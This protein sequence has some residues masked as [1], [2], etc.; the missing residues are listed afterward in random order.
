M[1]N[2][3][4]CGGG[5]LATVCGGFLSA[6]EGVKVS[7]LT[8][9]PEAWSLTPIV[10]APNGQQ[11]QGR[12]ELVT[13][14]PQE[15]VPQA[16]IVLL[17][18]PAFAIED[19]LQ[20]IKPWL[21]PTTVVGSIVANTGFFFAAHDLLPATQPLFGFQRVPFIARTK[22]YGHEAQ[23]MGYKAQLHV[24]IEHTGDAEALRRELERIFCTPTHLLH[25]F[26]EAS[27]SN[28]NPILH[29]GRLYTLW[30][31]WKGETLASPFRFYD[32]WTVEASEM[33]LQMDA[34]F[35]CLTHHLGITEKSIPSLLTYYES[36]DAQSLTRKL[37]GIEAFHGILAPMKET[38]EGWVPDFGSRYFTEDFPY[39]LRFIRDLLVQENIDAPFIEKVYQWGMSRAER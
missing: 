26:Y 38:A 36:T 6:Q 24:A 4:I 37:Q 15:V 5:N 20:Q 25:S 32:E 11:F 35:M 30:K 23:L 1:L 18:L 19:V 21:Q 8:R 13:N 2:I 31:D 39:G 3:T 17:C 7:L 29:T 22:T 12:L 27:L 9:H 34:E 16:D 33:I 28:S 10:M 14:V